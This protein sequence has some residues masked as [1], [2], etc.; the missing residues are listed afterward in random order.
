[1]KQHLIILGILLPLIAGAPKPQEKASSVTTGSIVEKHGY[2]FE[3]HEVQTS[4][5]YILGLH[6]IP[7]SSRV[8]S[9]GPR[10]AVFLMHGLLCSSSDW[11]LL[12]P[13]YALGYRLADAGYDV[14]MGNARG[15]TYSKNHAT[16]H[17]LLPSFWKFD[18]HEI[19]LYDLPAMIDYVLYET[20]QDQVHYFGHS[21][22]TT[23]FL[24]L[25]SLN[26]KFK[27]RIKSAHLLAPVA[28]MDN[29]KSPLVKLAAPFM[30]DPKSWLNIFGNTQ[31]MPN[32]KIMELLGQSACNDEA[33]YQSLC[34]NAI[35][36]MAGY[37]DENMNA[38]LL[39]EILATTPAGA[40]TNQIF[41]YLQEYNSGKFR[42]F[43]EGKLLKKP[44]NYPIEKIDVPIYLYY[45]ENDYMSSEVDV[46][47][48]MRKLKPSTL[49][50]AHK[51]PHPKWNHLD[52]LWG[53]NINE[54]VHDYIMENLKEINGE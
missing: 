17:P 48:L 7:Y 2:P 43:D 51:V 9:E 1:M 33:K 8:K 42:E 46:E 32:T 6:R 23:S 15:N 38:T 10:P 27:N 45:S 49:R 50:G 11:V 37:D 19:G 24:V 3:E 44:K 12:G 28:F 20:G 31:F 36:L 16:L 26:K 21:Q 30:G 52:Y 25:N 54:L 29:M 5:G 13:D 41:H 18:W 39:P 4:D 40:S 22:G 14:W 47:K 53:L 35:F 34:A